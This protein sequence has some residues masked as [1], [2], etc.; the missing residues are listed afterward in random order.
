MARSTID[1]LI[2]N[3]PAEQ[4]AHHWRYDCTTHRLDL[5]PSRRPAGYVVA[6]EDSRAFDDP[7]TRASWSNSKVGIDHGYTLVRQAAERR[8]GRP[9]AKRRGRSR[10]KRPRDSGGSLS[11]RFCPHTIRAPGRRT[12]Q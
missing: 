11:W 1:R 6:S 8:A 5:A 10:P 7:G 3:S 2:V 9:R 12:L 4:P